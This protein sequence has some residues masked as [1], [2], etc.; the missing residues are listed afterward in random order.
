MSSQTVF[1]FAPLGLFLL[2]AVVGLGLRVLLFRRRT[3]ANPLVHQTR[4]SAGG[5]QALI[6]K[7]HSLVALLAVALLVVRA[8]CPATPEE[9][10]R[11]RLLELPAV[12]WAGLGVAFLAIFAT[13]AFQGAMGRSWRIGIPEGQTTELVTTGV[14]A[15]SRNPI[16]LGLNVQFAGLFALLPTTAVGLLLITSFL[17][18]RLQVELEEQ[19][20]VRTHGEAYLAYARRVGR[21]LPWFGRYPP[22]ES[23]VG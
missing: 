3:G 6:E 13:F 7:C 19:W 9:L 1:R 10:G 12:Q 15:F 17:L 5:V 16:Y 18:T 21:F 20:L 22:G 4:Q 14:F 8:A 23:A 11:L 2:F